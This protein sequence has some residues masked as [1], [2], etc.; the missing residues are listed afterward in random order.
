[1]HAS[2]GASSLFEIEKERTPVRSF[3]FANINVTNRLGSFFPGCKILL[4]LIGEGVDL[5]AHLF[6]F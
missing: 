2:T 1:M 4:L 3:C 6:E 5:H